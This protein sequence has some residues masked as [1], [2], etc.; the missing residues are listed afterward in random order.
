MEND[1]ETV[2][3]SLADW[4]A[5]FAREPDT[6][7]FGREHSDLGRQTYKY[8]KELYGDKRCRLLDLG[9]GEG[10]DAVYFASR[11]FE[12]TAADGSAVAI[13]KAKRLAREAAVDLVDLRIQDVREFPLSP[14]FD[15]VFSCNC[16]QFLGADCLPKL[17]QIQDVTPPGGMNAVA[18]FT[19]ESEA[20]TAR[21]DLYRFDR[22]ELKFHYVERGWRLLYYREELLW[23]EPSSNYYS[24]A[25]IIAVKPDGMQ[26]GSMIRPS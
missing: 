8:W 20:L 17:H 1:A 18:A 22:N 26:N 15:V 16:L 13:A 11:G 4:D 21:T 25:A 14:D 9:C 2:P 7:Y 24:F 23:R 10:R 19:R 6:W 12:V 3:A 5:T